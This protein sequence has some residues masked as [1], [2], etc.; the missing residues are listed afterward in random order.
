MT[1]PE[2]WRGDV[3]DPADSDE[4]PWHED[5]DLAGWP[6]ELAGPEYWMFHDED[7]DTE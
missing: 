2:P 5:F 1:A 7:E 3:P 4:P 6:E